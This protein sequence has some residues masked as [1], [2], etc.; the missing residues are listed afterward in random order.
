MM[1]SG[2]RHVVV[3]E[4]VEG[5]SCSPECGVDHERSMRNAGEPANGRRCCRS[6]R[7]L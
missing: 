3:V 2:S 4:A 7:V 6:I 1:S 5:Y